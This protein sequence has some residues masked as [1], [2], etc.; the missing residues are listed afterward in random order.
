MGDE[1]PHTHRGIEKLGTNIL[2][3]ARSLPTSLQMSPNGSPGGYKVVLILR[4]E[5]LL[6]ILIQGV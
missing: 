5:L 4:E 3:F 6:Q 1:N 2:S